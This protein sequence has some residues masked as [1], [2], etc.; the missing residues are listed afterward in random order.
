MFDIG[1]GYGYFTEVVKKKFKTFSVSGMDLNHNKL[2][3]GKN[4]LK[5]NFN[6]IY[7]KIED[8]SFIK[9]N[10][11]NFDIITSWHVLEHVFDPILWLKNI[12]RLLKKGGYIILELPNEDDELIKLSS[13]YSNIVHFQDHVN[14]FTKNTL[15]K[16]F[17][18][19]GIENYEIKGIQRYGFYNYID[20][21]RFNTKDKVISDDYR[22]IK[23]EPRSEIEKMW[24]KYREDNLIADTLFAVIKK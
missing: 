24:I 5:L 2:N 19:C 13:G 12:Y 14:Y 11:E 17:E 1:T 7:N 15:Q 23:D 9:K 21:I 3:Y 4:T 22:N 18:L 20:W 10:E 16:L 8:E 6:A